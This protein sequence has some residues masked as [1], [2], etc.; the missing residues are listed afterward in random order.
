MRTLAVETNTS[1]AR[2]GDIDGRV[3]TSQSQ[4]SRIFI[5]YTPAT[6]RLRKPIMPGHS[7][8]AACKSS[9]SRRGKDEVR[10]R[11]RAPAYPPNGIASKGGRI[12]RFRG[13][14]AIP[15]P[16]RCSDPGDAHLVPK[17]SS[18]VLLREISPR[19]DDRESDSFAW[20]KLDLRRCGGR[21]GKQRSR[22][23]PCTTVRLP[24]RFACL[25][26]RR[27]RS[28][29]LPVE[30]NRRFICEILIPGD[31]EPSD[32]GCAGLIRPCGQTSS[33]ELDDSPAIAFVVGMRGNYS[34]CS[35]PC[36]RLP[37]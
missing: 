12:A 37:L 10:P 22:T 15:A 29:T 14:P 33:P 23:R 8:G 27:G 3:R 11:G 21:F 32:S 16:A 24:V 1:L 25:L 34:N 9:S 31:V 35:S 36:A 6:R 30:V 19:Y 4:T 26:E 7:R 2:R 28:A 5:R 20:R 18:G 17:V 13:Y